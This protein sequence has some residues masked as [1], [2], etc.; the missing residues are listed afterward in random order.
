MNRLR[1]GLA[2]LIV[3]PLYIILTT[4][5]ATAK[6]VPFYDGELTPDSDSATFIPLRIENHRTVDAIPP[7]FVLSGSGRHDLGPVGGMGGVLERFIDASWLDAERCLTITAHYV[8]GRDLVFDK[9]C[10]RKG[11]RIS[12]SLD[13]IF[14]PGS[15]WSHR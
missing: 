12:A 1:A 9:A 2:L 5:C 4:G 3:V 7:H 6:G 15:S 11:E 14:I 10:W 13:N 8:G